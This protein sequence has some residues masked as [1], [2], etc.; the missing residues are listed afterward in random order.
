MVGRDHRD[1]S[2]SPEAYDMINEEFNLVKTTIDTPFV[3]GKAITN[4]VSKKTMRVKRVL[5]LV[6]DQTIAEGDYMQFK[7]DESVAI[8]KPMDLLMTADFGLF[9]AS[10]IDDDNDFPKIFK[11]KR[12]MVLANRTSTNSSA[13]DFF[14]IHIPPRTDGIETCPVKPVGPKILLKKDIRVTQNG[15]GKEIQL[16]IAQ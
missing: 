4:P 5:T 9:T 10:S 8:S 16:S 6:P 14:L 7:F 2:L 1:R 15:G 12:Q 3:S 11:K 13:E